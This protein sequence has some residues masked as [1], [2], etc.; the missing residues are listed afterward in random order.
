MR[1]AYPT[2]ELEVIAIFNQNGR[3]EKGKQHLFHCS[4]SAQSIQ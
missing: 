1:R 2:D 4:S 3:K